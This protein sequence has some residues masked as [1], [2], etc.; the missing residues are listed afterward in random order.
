MIFCKTEIT[1]FI[2]KKSCIIISL[3]LMTLNSAI[4]ATIAEKANL[5]INPEIF[6]YTYLF[7]W[8]GYILMV[9][10][11]FSTFIRAIKMWNLKEH[12]RRFE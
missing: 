7:S 9:Y 8:G 11:V 3:F 5:G 6:T 10:L 1:N 4:I 12:K 2:L